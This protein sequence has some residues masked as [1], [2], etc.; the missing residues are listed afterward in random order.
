M[1]MIQKREKKKKAKIKIRDNWKNTTKN[2]WLWVSMPPHINS[3]TDL[4]KCCE[5]I[6]FCE[7]HFLIYFL[8]SFLICNIVH[9]TDL[10]LPMTEIVNW[11]HIVPMRLRS[12]S[13]LAPRHIVLL[14]KCLT[15]W[16]TWCPWCRRRRSDE[17]DYSRPTEREGRKGKREEPRIECRHDHTMIHCLQQ[18]RKKRKKWTNE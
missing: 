10:F 14:W 5:M 3:S 8:Y 6:F 1:R 9:A 4:L 16:R 15:V 18:E 2:N 13:P 17:R 11:A 12:S 7:N